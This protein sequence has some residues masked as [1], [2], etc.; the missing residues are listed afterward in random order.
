MCAPAVGFTCVKG[1]LA[2]K[3]ERRKLKFN[4]LKYLFITLGRKNHAIQA[5]YTS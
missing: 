4:V 5:E 2:G 3:R 1:G